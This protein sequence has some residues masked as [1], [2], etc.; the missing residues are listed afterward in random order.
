[1]TAV[2]AT[3]SL[4]LPWTA[5]VDTKRAAEIWG[6]SPKV[7]YDRL[8]R[9]A[10]LNFLSANPYLV[11][12]AI[13]SRLDQPRRMRIA[14]DRAL[15]RDPDNW[16][17]TLELAALDAIEGET[18]SALERLQ[19]VSELNP[20]EPVT[21]QV[22]QGLLSDRP[23]SLERLDAIFLER[24]CQRLGRAVGPGGCTSG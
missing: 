21:D 11:A 7:A 12:G 23:V 4:A 14:F 24:Y 22:R 19:R 3:L 10:D 15:D 1:V 17:A 9:A 8:D 18:L 13:A 20:R 5:A 2:L 16:Y 6:A